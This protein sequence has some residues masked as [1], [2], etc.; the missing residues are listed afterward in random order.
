MWIENFDNYF[1][2]NMILRPCFMQKK[3][4][5]LFFIQKNMKSYASKTKASFCI[6][7]KNLLI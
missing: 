6:T 5:L 1:K 3:M 7:T 4:T 2:V